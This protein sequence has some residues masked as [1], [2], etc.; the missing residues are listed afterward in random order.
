MLSGKA[1]LIEV[2]PNGYAVVDFKT[3]SPAS[4][5]EVQAGFDPQ[6]PLTAIMLA[7]GSIGD[8]DAGPTEDLIYAEVKGYNDKG[9][10]SSLVRARKGLPAV[11]YAASAR[12]ELI[13]LIREFDNPA[14]PYYS[15]PRRKFTHDWSDFDDL[16]RRGEWAEAGGEGADG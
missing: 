15:Q 11:D 13:K 2:G 14:T 4:V 8:L 12:E 16:A 5:P 3:G 6:L 10:E 9:V 7:E 1:D